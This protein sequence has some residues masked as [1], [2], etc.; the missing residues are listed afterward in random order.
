[1]AGERILVV[2]DDRLLRW[3]L[4]RRLAEEGFEVGEAATLGEAEAALEGETPDLVLLDHRLPDGSGLE[5]IPR[6]RADH[7]ETAIVMLTGHASVDRAV[8][9][10]KAGA[11]DYLAKPVEIE[12]LLAV[13]RRALE[14][15]RLRRE[16]Q[17]LREE[18]LHRHGP[19]TLVGSSPAMRHVLALVEKV[20]ASPG[21][22]V[23][24]L[25]E[26]GT[27]KDL[28]ARAIHLASPR[29]EGPF[30]ALDCTAFPETLLEGELFGHEKGA[31]TGAHAR[32][33]GLLE[34][35]DGGTVFLDEVG[36]MGPGAQAKLLRFLEERTVRRL[37]GTRDIPVDVRVIAATNRDLEA[38]VRAG[39]FREDLF[40]RL[41]VVPIHLPPLRERRGDVTLLA[42]HFLERFSREQRKRLEGFE[43]EALAA[44][45]RYA[46][47]GNVR[48]LRNL[49]ERLVILCD[50]PRIRL[51]DLPRHVRGEGE[52]GGGDGGIRLPPGGVR[53]ADVERSLVEQ[54]LVRTGGNVTR[55]A[56]L[57]GISRDALRYRLKKLGI[58][59][60]TRG[61]G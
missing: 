3:S 23:L 34:L 59:G 44:L 51:A 20:A 18:A 28:L 43:P 11:F 24:L 27:G 13:V 22:T 50:G 5:A 4:A 58:P 48:E 37:G 26:S 21:T 33:R 54:A 61:R 7:P 16:L 41:Q 35:A 10:I 38:D 55:A 14:T 30:L 29:A 40:F 31:Y 46:W 36:E 52:A 6:W 19:E 8:R 25:G 57:L 9:A 32:R 2:D 39:R 49:V 15:T 56:R 17:R 53:L 12:A 1:M 60:S 47:P 45:E 42:T